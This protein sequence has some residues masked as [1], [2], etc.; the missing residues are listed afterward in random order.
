MEEKAIR[1]GAEKSLVGILTLPKKEDRQ[2]KLPAVIILNSG[3]LHRVG[4]NRIYVRMARELAAAGITVFRFDF[5]GVGDSAKDNTQRSYEERNIAATRAAMDLLEKK[6]D[7]NSFMITGICSGADI[8]FQAARIDDRIIGIAPIDFYSL[9]STAYLINAYKKRLI[10]PHSWSNLFSGKSEVFSIFKKIF[11][12]ITFLK[13]AAASDNTDP[14]AQANL[15]A[16]LIAGY[17]ELADRG[18]NL[19]FLFSAGSPAYFNYQTIFAK[20]VAA[21]SA[22]RKFSVDYFETADH[23]FTL[24]YHQQQLIDAIKDWA[25]PGN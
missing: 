16:D 9:P 20:K 1:F 11:T 8:S 18:L 17:Q 14:N 25:A 22:A 21:L 15:E 23:G 12:N 2:D 7:I 3:L 13:T 19:R 24:L 5:A 10:T 6:Q 4:P